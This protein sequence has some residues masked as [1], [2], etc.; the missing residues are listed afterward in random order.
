ML[1]PRRKKMNAVHLSVLALAGVSPTLRRLPERMIPVVTEK[2]LVA[3]EA[4]KLRR[5]A[6]NAKRLSHSQGK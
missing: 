5:A 1:D 6:R 2:D 3:I 4:A